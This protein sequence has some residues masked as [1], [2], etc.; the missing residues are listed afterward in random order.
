[1]FVK[2]RLMT[3]G[4]TQVAEATRIA[5]GSSHP[6]HRGDE[7]KQTFMRVQQGLS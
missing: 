2:T 5:L 1:M 4:P 7:F 3:P 6:H